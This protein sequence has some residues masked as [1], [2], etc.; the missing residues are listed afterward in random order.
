MSNRRTRSKLVQGPQLGDTTFE[1]WFETPVF[2][3]DSED[4]RLEQL[5]TSKRA[6]LRM[7]GATAISLKARRQDRRP[8][9]SE[10]S[11]GIDPEELAEIVDLR[12]DGL[13]HRLDGLLDRWARVEVAGQARLEDLVLP[14]RWRG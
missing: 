1:E 10:G 9:D 4:E 8:I 6:P 11:A 7:V 3:C 5:A 12:G 2:D 14:K 13:R